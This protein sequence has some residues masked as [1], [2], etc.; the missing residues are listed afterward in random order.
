[1]LQWSNGSGGGWTTS[2]ECGNPEFPRLCHTFKKQRPVP[3]WLCFQHTSLCLAPNLEHFYFS[4]FPT[5]MPACLP[6][7]IDGIF[8]EIITILNVGFFSSLCLP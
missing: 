2:K 1:M 4:P 7:A 8:K 6:D 3:L 5:F